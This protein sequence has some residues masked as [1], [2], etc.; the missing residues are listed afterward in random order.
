[1]IAV[2][3]RNAA[4]RP[5]IGRASGSRFDAVTGAITVL[6][7]ASQWPRAVENAVAGS[8]IAATFVRP[9]DYKA[10]QIKGTIE[11]VRPADSFEHARGSQYVDDMLAVLGALG[12]TRLQLSSTLS[13][14]DLTCIR[15]RPTELYIQTPGPEVGQRLLI[16]ETA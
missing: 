3:T 9:G 4:H 6:V 5:M 14:K 13:D 8:P 12:V 16:G 11:S 2:S 10:Y 7:S 1:M 15:F